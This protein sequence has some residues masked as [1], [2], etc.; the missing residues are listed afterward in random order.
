MFKFNFPADSCDRTEPESVVEH[1]SN[2]FK[3]SVQEIEGREIVIN[4]DQHENVNQ[5]RKSGLPITAI[6]NFHLV[7][8]KHIEQ[9]IST[10][11][12]ENFESLR[13]A[14][15]MNSDV[16]SGVYEGKYCFK[17]L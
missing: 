3:S 6:H 11:E 2:D 15:Q 4:M 16:I 5:Y 10:K 17:S 1:N 13:S 8:V 12:D 7:D 9:F 14:L